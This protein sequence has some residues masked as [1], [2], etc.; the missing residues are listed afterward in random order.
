MAKDT[1][2][3]D[4]TGYDDCLAHLIPAAFDQNRVLFTLEVKN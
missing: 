3:I 4:A 1:E 2:R